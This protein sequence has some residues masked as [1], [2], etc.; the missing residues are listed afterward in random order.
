MYNIRKRILARKS[1]LRWKLCGPVPGITVDVFLLKSPFRIP[2]ENSGPG[3]N[4]ILPFS[5]PQ[6]P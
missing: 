4:H 1:G 2:R 3:G 6:H 5:P